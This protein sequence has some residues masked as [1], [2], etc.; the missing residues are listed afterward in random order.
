MVINFFDLNW[1]QI[2]KTIQMKKKSANSLQPT[3]FRRDDSVSS[4]DIV[5][6]WSQGK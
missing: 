4:I 6:S 3:I 1:P 2:S 5:I